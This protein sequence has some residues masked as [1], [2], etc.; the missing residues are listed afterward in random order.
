MLLFTKFKA[1]CIFD[2][3]LGKTWMLD[4][5]SILASI[6]PGQCHLAA[7]CPLGWLT[8]L[9]TCHQQSSHRQTPARQ[10]RG[11]LIKLC[12]T[13]HKTWIDQYPCCYRYIYAV[14]RKLHFC[15][16]FRLQLW[17]DCSRLVLDSIITFLLLLQR[18]QLPSQDWRGGAGTLAIDS[19]CGARPQEKQLPECHLGI[20]YWHWPGHRLTA[21][22]HTHFTGCLYRQSLYTGCL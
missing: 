5:C 2:R 16:T 7:P 13:F 15:R 22:S 11:K 17:L 14:Q 12:H 4:M 19:S 3:G 6:R 9:G 21:T 1:S 18:S 10:Q 8:F 20:Q